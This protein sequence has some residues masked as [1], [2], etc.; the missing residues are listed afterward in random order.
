MHEH[1][2]YIREIKYLGIAL[3]IT[4]TFFI[5]ELVG[6]IL[7]NSLAL[8]TDAWHML[9][10]SFALVFS[11]VTAWIARRPITERKT[12]G[13]YRAEVLASFLQGIFLCAIVLLIFYE[14]VQRVQQPVDVMSL[15]ML[16]IAIS[17]LFA[18]GLSAAI[19]S[20]AKEESLNVK[21]A[22]LHVVT[23]IL[24]SLGAIT[25]SMIMIFTGWYQVDSLISILIGVL[26]F[27]GSGKLI[28]ESINVLLE[29]VPSNIDLNAMQDKMLEVEG[30]KSVHDLHVWCITPTKMCIMS[31]H[32]V[33]EEGANKKELMRFLIRMLKEEFGIDHT[34]IQFEDEGYPKA[35]KEH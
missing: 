15:N 1:S 24:G 2:N 31:G 26:I 14:A 32:V 35:L 11:L 16:I 19:L 18:N 29:G 10:D 34:T 8:L 33:V 28:R 5:I 6:G 4:I 25:A 30:I 22:F 23:D 7:T 27:Y 9:N 3:G 12:Y 20:K 21:G 17:G 13:Y